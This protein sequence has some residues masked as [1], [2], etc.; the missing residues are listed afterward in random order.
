MAIGEPMKWE[1]DY[2]GNPKSIVVPAEGGTYTLRCK[3]YQNPWLSNVSTGDIVI[4]AGLESQNFHHIE[5]DWYN[6]MVERN[7]Y[8]I[9]IKPNTSG[10]DRKLLIH[11]TAGDIFDGIEVTQAK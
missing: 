10:N 11:V 7:A 4:Y 5:H 8:R 9:I 6:I 3:N 1:A 2:P